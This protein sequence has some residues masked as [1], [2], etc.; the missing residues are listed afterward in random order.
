M[1]KIKLI[2]CFHSKTRMEENVRKF[3]L[4]NDNIKNWEKVW[5][6]HIQDKYRLPTRKGKISWFDLRKII[7]RSR[8]FNLCQILLFFLLLLFFK[9]LLRYVV[10]C[11]YGCIF[12][13]KLFYVTLCQMDWPKDILVKKAI[14]IFL[15]SIFAS[16]KRNYLQNEQFSGK[17][18]NFE[19]ENY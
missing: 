15:V 2:Y 5:L 13:A 10:W 16:F 9:L 6:Y 14:A 8:K 11:F 18:E 3:F 7:K 17:L 19:K 12:F 4:S 1:G